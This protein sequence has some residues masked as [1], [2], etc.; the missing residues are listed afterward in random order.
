M[1]NFVPDPGSF[2]DPSGRIYVLG[3][4]VYR[5]ITDYAARDFEYVRGTG[6]IDRLVADGRL[7]GADIVP[8]DVLGEV[9]KDARYVV[10]HPRLPFV[11][12]PYEWPFPALKAAALLHL[13]IHLA[14]LDAG[15]TLSDATAYNVQFLGTRPVFIDLLSFQKYNKGDMWTGHRQFCEQF[16]NPLLLRSEVGVVHNHWY[17]GAQE[18]LS[19]SDLRRI[20]PWRSKLSRNV[21]LHVIAQSAFQK[22]SS[23]TTLSKSELASTQFPLASYHNMLTKL[24]NWIQMLQ[25]AD[26]GKT[27]W[28]D[29]EKH[30]SYE[31]HEFEA[32]KAFIG[33]FVSTVKPKILWDLGCN[34]GDFSKVALENGA[35]YTVGFDFDQG[36]LELAFDRAETNDLTIQPLF[37]DGANPSPSQGW[38]ECER[39]GLMERANAEALIALAFIHHIVIGKNVPL[40]DVTGWLTNLAPRGVI[41]F[42]PKQDPMVKKLLSLREDIFADYTE[43]NFARSLSQKVTIVQTETI[44]DSGRKLFWFERLN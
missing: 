11:S 3:D 26:T 29:Y 14:A 9:G 12:Y 44:T 10:E 31:G 30:H 34:T 2:R 19:A 5:T 20:L 28:H 32:K 24:R 27:V 4:K 42:V 43:D 7:I 40:V 6:L 37:L 1:N 33:K 18:G 35:A 36:A 21:L 15:V 23:T 16:L 39:K 22:S 41:E 17:R 13:D 25:P 38:N 8:V